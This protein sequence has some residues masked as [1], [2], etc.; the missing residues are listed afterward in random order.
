MW[1][2]GAQSNLENFDRTEPKSTCQMTENKSPNRL[3]KLWMDRASTDLENCG[4]AEPEP[5]WRNANG[6][7]PK[8]PGE[9]RQHI[10]RTDLANFDG[11]SPNRLGEFRKG[12]AQT[13]LANC[14][15]EDPKPTWRPCRWAE[16]DSTT[17]IPDHEP[18]RR[19][20]RDRSGV[21]N[22]VSVKAIMVQKS[23]SVIIN[24]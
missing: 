14:G 23:F 16:S 17:L 19:T 13:D 7:S 4:K 18:W 11:Q 22:F 5:T 10:A 2:V 12:R 8:R 15:R 6:R 21:F 3:G 24:L 20:D 1:M 9:L